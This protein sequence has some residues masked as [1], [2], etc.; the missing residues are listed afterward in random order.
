MSRIKT[1]RKLSNPPIIR[2]FNPYG[3]LVDLTKTESVILHYE[4]FEA[5]KLCDYD[6]LTH[7]QASIL[8]HIS[9]PTF[10]RIYAS[11]R[12]KIAISFAEG[13]QIEVE[14]GKI[15]FESDWYHCNQCQSHF[16]NPDRMLQLTNCPLCGSEQ[17][18]NAKQEDK[19]ITDREEI[20]MHLVCAHCGYDVNMQVINRYSKTHC[21]HCKRLMRGNSVLKNQI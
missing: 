17:I 9:R 14:G 15:Y 7:H 21:P 8:M 10:T 4:E 16:N 18:E 2:G 5:F 1:P 6:H 3:P 12:S 13:R 19:S 11:A 20:S